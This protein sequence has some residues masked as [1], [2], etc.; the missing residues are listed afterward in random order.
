MLIS[1]LEVVEDRSKNLGRVYFGIISSLL[2]RALTPST[3]LAYVWWNRNIDEK[4]K[5]CP[6]D[7]HA[8]ELSSGLAN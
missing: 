5:I 6:V 1:S 4:F 8:T 7:S 3:F 2:G